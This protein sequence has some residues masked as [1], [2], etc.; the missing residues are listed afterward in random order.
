[1]HPELKGR[2]IT[3]EKKNLSLPLPSVI[4]GRI[5]APIVRYGR[6]YRSRKPQA[7]TP[8]AVL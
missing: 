3:V 8:A 6:R 4:C 7:G 2:Q 5:A 1:M